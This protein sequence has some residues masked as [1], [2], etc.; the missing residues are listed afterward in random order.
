[1]KVLNGEWRPLVIIAGLTVVIIV[2]GFLFYFAN[3]DFPG[4][5]END[6]YDKGVYYNEY[7]DRL[8]EQKARGWQL[9]L[10]W[11]AEPVTGKPATLRCVVKDK[12][13]Q[14]IRGAIVNVKLMRPGEPAADQRLVLQEVGPGDYQGTVTLPRPGNWDLLLKMHKGKDQHEK[15]AEVWAIPAAS[16]A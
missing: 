14:P 1:M 9:N 4:I 5:V 10:G 2:N 13:G 15:Q 3:H 16:G 12:S 11:V 6:Y 7:L 8:K